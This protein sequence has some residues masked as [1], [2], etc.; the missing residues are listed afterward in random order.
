[1]HYVLRLHSIHYT[2]ARIRIVPFGVL[3]LESTCL[4]SPEATPVLFA[5]P[6]P[7]T[8]LCILWSAFVLID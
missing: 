3:F 4:V 7:I 1:M 8:S 6:D 5:P 2:A